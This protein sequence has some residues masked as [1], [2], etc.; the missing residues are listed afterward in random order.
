MELKRL[1][2]LT[3]QAIDEYNL[4]D[5]GDRIA[6][7]ISGGKDSLT[8]LYALSELR[9]FYPKKFELEAISVDVGFGMDFEPVKELCDKLDVDFTVVKTQI[10]TIVFEER[11]ESNPCSLCAKLR[12]GA[13]YKEVLKHNC[14]KVAYGHHKDDF[15]NTM[16]LSLFYEGRFQSLET[17]FTLDETNIT[18]I[19]P[20]IYVSEQNVIGFKNKYNLPVVKNFCPVDKTTR[21]EYVATLVREIN[22]ENPGVKDRLFSAVEKQFLKPLMQ[23]KPE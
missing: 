7:A 4:I 6:V 13:L 18:V 3:R 20:L 21:R 9:R 19:R 5:D 8:L 12:K 22:K 2:S 17:K 14:N 1:L 15:V 10:N 16:L 23:D 11:K